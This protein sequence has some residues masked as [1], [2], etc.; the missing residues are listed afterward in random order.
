MI[1]LLHQQPPNV[2][3]LVIPIMVLLF[4]LTHL[5]FVSLN[6]LIYLLH[7]LLKLKPTTLA[8]HVMTQ[9]LVYLLIWMKQVIMPLLISILQKEATVLSSTW[10]H[11]S[12]LANI[13]KD[14]TLLLSMILAAFTRLIL[15]IAFVHFQMTM[16]L[17]LK[18]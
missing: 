5:S 15:W 7:L 17:I 1:F 10:S 11:T 3:N 8:L 9:L 16:L 12:L 6:I 14:F 13:S 4:Q 2:I 18:F